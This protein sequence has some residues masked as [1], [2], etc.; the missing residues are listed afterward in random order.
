MDR[1]GEDLSLRLSSLDD[2]LSDCNLCGLCSE[3]CATFRASGWELDSPRGRIKLAHKL[4]DG[5]ISPNA[6]ILETFDRCLGC[7]ACE[8]LCPHEVSYGK[9]R[10]S[11]C[12]IRSLLS[13]DPETCMDQKSYAQWIQWAHRIGSLFWRSYGRR[14]LKY[15]GGPEPHPRSFLRARGQKKQRLDVQLTLVVGCLQDLFH[16]D[17]IESALKVFRALDYDVAI[18]RN[19]PCCGAIFERLVTGGKEAVLYSKERIVAERNQK[20]RLGVFMDWIKSPT[21]FLSASCCQFVKREADSARTGSGS[22]ALVDPYE[23]ILGILRDRNLTFFL[24]TPLKVYYQSYC[25]RSRGE[26]DSAYALLSRIVGLSVKK[27]EHSLTC[28]GGYCGESIW[29]PEESKLLFESKTRSL[30]EG[31][32]VVI[33][34]ADCHMQF[35]RHGAGLFTLLHPLQILSMARLSY[36]ST[37]S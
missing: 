30:S 19:Q 25:A 4:M 17:V 6:P 5:H 20:K 11:V 31:D 7:H 8:Q 27:M 9:I 35:L 34:G 12:D 26:L 15:P 29:R 37:L 23:L 33:A 32:I 13:P 2:L 10:K 16:Q 3:A 36:D 14:W 1:E 22:E 21:C 28:C 24:E 18:D